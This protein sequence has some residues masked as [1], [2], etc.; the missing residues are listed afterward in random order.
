[1]IYQLQKLWQI[2]INHSM[3]K[4]PL[5]I[6]IKPGVSVTTVA[7]PPTQLTIPI[8]SPSQS[9]DGSGGCVEDIY[10]RLELVK[11]I[12]I[13]PDTYVGSKDPSEQEMFVYDDEVKQMIKK[14]IKYIPSL[15]KICDEGIVNMRDHHVRMRDKI[16]KQAQIIAG[17]SPTDAKID[18]SRKYYP[19]K[20][21]EIMADINNGRIIFRNDGDGIDIAWHNV[22][23]MYVPELIFATF[24]TG[25]NFDQNEERTVGGKNGYGAKLINVLSKE[26]IIETVDAYRGLKYVQRFGNNMSFREDPIITKC[27]GAPYTQISFIPD[28]QWFG[29]KG[30]NDDDTVQLIRKRAYDIAAVTPKE[31]TVWYNNEKIEVRTFERY[32]DLYIG[33]RGQ[34]KRIY[35]VVNP[36]WEIAVCSSPDNTFEHVSFVNGVWTYRGGKHVEHASN[37]ISSRLAKYATEN[38]KGMSNISPTSIKANMWVFINATM[39]KPDFDTQTKENF[40][41]NIL[42]FR[43]RCDVDE[44]FITKLAQTKVGILERAVRLSEFK[45]GKGLKKSD[46]KKSKR[47][48]NLKAI[49][50]IYAGDKK[51]SQNCVL[52]L[53]EGDSAQTTAVAGLSAFTEEERKYYGVMPLKG[54]I[55]NPKDSKITTIEANKEFVEI[56]QILGLE[57]GV[58]YS[59]ALNKLRYGRI[60]LMTDADVDGDHIKGLGFNLFHEFW[61]SLLKIDGF[62]SSLLTPIVKAVHLSSNRVLNFYSMGELNQWKEQNEQTLSQWDINYYKGLGTHDSMEAQQIFREMKLQKYSWNDLTRMMQ[63]KE[64]VEKPIVT[65][66]TDNTINIEDVTPIKD[67]NLLTETTQID[68]TAPM[69]D[70][71][72]MSHY[73]DVSMTTNLESFK[74][75]YKNSNRNPCDLAM[76]LAFAKK[77]AD[78]RKGWITQYLKLK[79]NGQVDLDLHKLPIMSYYDFINEKLVEFSVY[80]NERSIPSIADGLKPSQRKILYTMLKKSFKKKVKVA[81]LAGIVSAFTSYHHGQASIEETIVGMAQDFP[82]SN[83]INLLLPLGQLGSRKGKA[84]K[85][86]GKD[87]ASSRYIYTNINPITKVIFNKIDENLYSYLDDDGKVVEPTFYLPTIPMILINGTRGIGTGWST[88]I[89][90]YNP[91]DVINNMELYLQG[92]PMYEMQ[93]WFRGF[94]GTIYKIS[95]Q[96]YRVTGVYQRTGPTTVEIT[97]IPVGSARESMSFMDYKNFIENLIIDTSVTDDKIRSKQ[98]LDDAEILLTDKT[99][100]CTLHFQSEEQ[101]NRLLSNL[102]T[103]ESQFKLSHIINTSNMNLFNID[104]IMTKYV[105]P[106]DILSEYCDIRLRYY[107]KRKNYMIKEWETKILQINEKIRFINYI[108]DEQHELKVQKRKKVDIIGLLEKYQF[109]KFVKTSNKKKHPDDENVGTSLSYDY[110]L[111][112]PIYSLTIEQIEKLQKERDE[113]QR[114][115]D[116]L[117]TT[118]TQKLWADD[119]V[120]VKAQLITFEKEWNKVYGDLLKTPQG[121]VC[122]PNHL[123]KKIGLKNPFPTTDNTALNP[124][125]LLSGNKL[126]IKIKS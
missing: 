105:N 89:P 102:T 119:L 69:D 68:T 63:R 59:N 43:S 57:Q 75:Y 36:D 95:H 40:T 12:L 19:V 126:V 39:V 115:L 106:E 122:L 53:T 104:G 77:Y 44:D 4:K 30:L 20:T 97:E 24:L 72:T 123:K 37:I 14:K 27:K 7:T 120:N 9:G 94:R 58:D 45:A 90:T 76:E 38:K 116:E 23:K 6:K 28:F 47:P 42:K 2:I 3:E 117:R 61:P 82:G 29:L 66:P 31:V 52:I 34:C 22:E 80:D 65:E 25:T 110:L 46:G 99:I 13:A 49:P 112:M 18:V 50:A 10:K 83:N 114:K 100:K 101:L 91:I 79:A 1:M 17:K 85:G 62:F 108:N 74:N 121:M 78:Y 5:V 87:A 64:I 21:I 96:K 118:S 8:Q 32:V 48:K 86:I 16:E 15:Y 103:F 124:I 70:S 35:T 88:D 55:I 67:I 84:D 125:T 113:T 109:M 54:K 56:K 60:I 73:S 111:K 81:E 92:K 51:R 41:T 11:H 98:V 26:F 33:T 71:D 107:G 93:P